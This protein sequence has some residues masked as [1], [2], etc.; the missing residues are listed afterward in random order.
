M[1]DRLKAQAAKIDALTLRERVFIFVAVLGVVGAIW[2]A[3]LMGPLEAREERT[4]KQL[5]NLQERVT[6]LN[7]SIDATASGLDDGMPDRLQRLNISPTLGV[8][9][10]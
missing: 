6:K 2:Q 4:S 8:F 5:T 3:A 1:K 7:E 10:V 9:G